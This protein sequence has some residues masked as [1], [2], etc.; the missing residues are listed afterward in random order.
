MSTVYHWTTRENANQI[1]IEGLRQ[2]SFVCRRPDD[3]NG[4]MCLSINLPYDINWEN[5]DPEASWQAVVPEHIEPEMIK[6]IT[7]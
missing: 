5:R 6:V 7:L 2:W 3:W 1:L 4:E